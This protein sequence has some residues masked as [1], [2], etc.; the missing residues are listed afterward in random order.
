MD[1]TISYHK[2]IFEY[3]VF[4]PLFS[5]IITHIMGDIHLYH[6]RG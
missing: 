4:F 3:A 5:G 1:Y 2:G 6:L